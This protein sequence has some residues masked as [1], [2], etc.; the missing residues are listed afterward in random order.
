MPTLVLKNPSAVIFQITDVGILIP[1]LGSDTFT[2]DEII[3]C[4]AG[5][6]VTRTAVLAGTLIAN[7]GVTD[8][9]TA[10][11]HKYLE[12]MWEIAGFDSADIGFWN[13]VRYFA[14][15]YDAG[16]DT[17][18]GFSD[19]SMAD[20]GTKAIKTLERLKALFPKFGNGRSAVVAIRSRAGGAV[21]RNIA[22]TADDDLDFLNDVYGYEHLLV[23]GTATIASAGSVAFANDLN[24]KIAAGAR[25]VPGA[26]A[27]GY[28]PVAPITANTFDV[29]LNGGGAPA[30]AAEPALIGKR[31]RF[32]SATTTVALRNATGM[33]WQND[34]NTITLGVDLPA[35]PVAADIFYIEEPGVAVNRIFCK[36]SNP[37][38]AAVPPSFASQGIVIVGIRSVAVTAT[39][40]MLRGATAFLQ[41]SFCET[42]AAGLLSL[43]ATGVSDF[44]LLPSYSDEA[45]TPATITVGVSLRTDGMTVN[46]GINFTGSS[47]A[48]VTF[49][50]QLLNVNQYTAG[51]A[52][53]SFAGIIVQGCGPGGTPTTNI[54]GD[55]IGNLGVA[56]SRRMRSLSPF[57]GTEIAI[58]FSHCLVY[59]V[60]ATGA[61]ASSVLRLDSVGTGISIQD[62]VGAT[63]NTGPGLDLT[64]ARDCNIF[65][66]TLAANTF[67][68]AAG[69]DIVGGGPVAYVH[70]DYARADLRDDFGNHVQGSAGSITGST[71]VVTNNGV[72]VI[73]Q[74][75]ICRATATGVVQTAQANTAANATGVV[76]V[77][78]SPATAAPAQLTMLVNGGGSWVQFDAAPAVGAIAYLSTATT[79]NAQTAIPAV[80]A[81]NQKLRL[82]I[83]LRVSGTLGFVMWHQE[84]LPVLA[85]GAA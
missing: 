81:T 44:R 17:N 21:Y 71:T 6:Q 35:V 14:V 25:I 78:Q 65:I 74:Y 32:D 1:A 34:T 51:S 63:G 49:R 69:Q 20:A 42:A 56:T 31:V 82:G 33:I 15:D 4:L 23:R 38:N 68:G 47:Y 61:G 37:N 76:G 45:T 48:C 39:T 58:Q 8:L 28:N 73:G 72:A 41:L 79:G 85:N 29:Q 70:A 75:K 16:L 43:V 80:V 62:V 50:P 54:G 83:V 60:D 3:R 12:S 18:V 59:G 9:S 24:D 30:L 36:S 66:G 40:I 57:A 46:G 26:N 84:V 19:L 7:D 53:Y 77:S 22:N 55:S 64:R 10:A 27:G 67:T 5:S 11:G 2:E 13:G 52:C